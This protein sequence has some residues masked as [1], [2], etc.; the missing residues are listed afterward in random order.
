MNLNFTASSP[1]APQPCAGGG[2]ENGFL[3]L[4][5]VGMVGVFGRDLLRWVG[6]KAWEKCVIA[7]QEF[8]YSRPSRAAAKDVVG[9]PE[10]VPLIAI[11][12]I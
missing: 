1:S 4:V 8:P 5:V 7:V 6:R 12:H 3:Y 10:D 2:Y 9:N 11:N